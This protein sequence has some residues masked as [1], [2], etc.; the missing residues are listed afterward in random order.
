[1]ADDDI[2]AVVALVRSHH[3]LMSRHIWEIE[4]EKPTSVKVSLGYPERLGGELLFA[5][6]RQS[7]WVVTFVG[8]W[9]Q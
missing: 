3:H 4:V 9:A 7:N 6:K 1:L 5:E 2:R 8:V